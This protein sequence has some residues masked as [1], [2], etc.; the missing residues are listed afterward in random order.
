MAEV[1]YISS[2][3]PGLF[4]S[5]SP[6][7]LVMNPGLV[8]SWVGKSRI[9]P[10]ASRHF[11]G[12]PKYNEKI[13]RPHYRRRQ[14]DQGFVVTGCRAGQ[15]QS[16]SWPT[17]LVE[18]ASAGVPQVADTAPSSLSRF[19]AAL[20]VAANTVGRRS[21]VNLLPA[22]DGFSGSRRLTSP[23]ETWKPTHNS[24]IQNLEIYPVAQMPCLP[25]VAD[26]RQLETSRSLS[27]PDELRHQG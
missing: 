25:M 5:Q 22:A 6:M 27:R 11:T 23:P 12:A 15:H 21:V 26:Q 13:S 4:L 10:C 2:A 16:P 9:R 8:F 17:P 14:G 24:Q 19:S 18:A 1:C 3:V 20:Q 7:S